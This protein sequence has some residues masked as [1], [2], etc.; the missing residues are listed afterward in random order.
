MQSAFKK[1]NPGELTSPGDVFQRFF[2]SRQ[3]PISTQPTTEM[4]FQM[5]ARG[6]MIY[7][8]CLRVFSVEVVLPAASR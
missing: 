2:V 3:Q 4:T 5:N 6:F 7:F 1:E 8:S